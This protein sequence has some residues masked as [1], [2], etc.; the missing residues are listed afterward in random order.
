MNS[1][2]LKT[3]AGGI[4]VDELVAKRIGISYKELTQERVEEYQLE[5]FKRTLRYAKERS[6]F[7]AEKYKDIDP[8]DINDL[9]DIALL[10]ASSEK[11]LAGNEW[12]FRCID[13]ASVDRIVTVP[14]TGTS[15]MQKRLSFDEDDQRRA[16]EF[17]QKGYEVMNC[18]RGEKMLV[19]MSG[20]ST[21]SIGDLVYKAVTPLG[22]TIDVFG[23]VTDIKEAYE[24]LMDLKPEVIEAVPWHAAALASYGKRFGNPEKEFI[25]SANLSADVVPDSIVQRLEKLWKCTVHRHYGSTEMCIFGGVECSNHEGYHLR[26]CDILY[27]IPETDEEGKGEIIITTLDRKAMPL[28]RYKT[29]DIGKFTDKEC[30]CGGKLKRLLK[31]Y[32]RKSSIIHLGKVDIFLSDIADAVYRCDEVVD[33]DISVKD[34]QHMAICVKYLEGYPVNMD[35]VK[36]DILSID[37]IKGSIADNNCCVEISLEETKS[38]PSGYNLKKNIS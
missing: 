22:M 1:F 18:Q 19:L 2:S 5:A 21:G 38:F 33:F 13:A 35:N 29:G 14:T 6:D 28:I 34:A 24:R 25:R 8:D 20:N 31:V 37:G 30:S 16:I 11:D 7:Y 23:S 15:G 17:I 9:N 4:P 36:N 27:E 10:P 32:G 3:D 26:P 12:R